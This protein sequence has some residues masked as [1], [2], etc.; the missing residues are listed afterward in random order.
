MVPIYFFI[1]ILLLILCLT[2]FTTLQDGFLTKRILLF[3][4]RRF[5]VEQ[6]ERV[7]PQKNNGKW[8]YGVVM[9]IWSVKGQKLTLQPNDPEPFLE[10]L[11]EQAPQAKFLI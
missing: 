8:S 7:E 4:F 1:G 6:I 2:T 3:P 5:P 10:L 9:N 11:R